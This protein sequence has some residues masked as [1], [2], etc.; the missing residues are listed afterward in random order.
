MSISVAPL[1]SFGYKLALNAVE[2]PKLDAEFEEIT[3]GEALTKK[4][5]LKKKWPVR[6]A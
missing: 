3:E 5:N 6:G 1:G 4:V 2:L